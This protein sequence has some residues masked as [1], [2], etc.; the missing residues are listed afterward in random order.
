MADSG[1]SRGIYQAG[2]DPEET[3]M[4]SWFNRSGGS[5]PISHQITLTLPEVGEV[6]LRTGVPSERISSEL[7][8]EMSRVKRIS[9]FNLV[10][11][12]RVHSSAR[13]T[14][15]SHKGYASVRKFWKQIVAERQFWV[16]AM[17][18]QVEQKGR[19]VN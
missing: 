10:Q 8:L 14:V 2:W 6:P 18:T 3:R 16:D 15:H 11:R 5:P 17:R 13:R 7:K 4:S 9:K 1:S 12:Q 19:Q